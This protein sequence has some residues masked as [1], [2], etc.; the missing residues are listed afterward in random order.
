MIDNVTPFTPTAPA[1]LPATMLPTEMDGLQAM[2]AKMALCALRDMLE[3]MQP[4][5]TCE[6]QG[7]AALVDCIAESIPADDEP[8]DDEP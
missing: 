2:R 7:L 3:G 1:P 5:V 8:E 6:P 4:G